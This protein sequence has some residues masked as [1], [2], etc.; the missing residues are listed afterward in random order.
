MIGVRFALR[1]LLAAIAAAC[2]CDDRRPPPRRVTDIQALQAVGRQ[3]SLWPPH[4]PSARALEYS[5]ITASP[6]SHCWPSDPS[7]SW[8]VEYGMDPGSAFGPRIVLGTCKV[9]AHSGA[10]SCRPSRSLPA[11][12]ATPLPFPITEAAALRAVTS[13]SPAM[14]AHRADSGA[15][16]APEVSV[17][18]R[19]AE[20]CSASD[21]KCQWELGLLDPDPMVGPIELCVVDA[22]SGVVRC[23]AH[24]VGSALDAGVH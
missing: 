20:G 16:A 13:L 7:C 6:P 8:V 3:R 24:V 4:N 9:N 18:V 19:P 5:G 23:G 17:F 11:P 2:S 14:R 10:A 12:S 21:F 22:H 1:G 15:K